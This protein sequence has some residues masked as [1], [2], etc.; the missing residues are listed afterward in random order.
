VEGKR[1]SGGG[2]GEGGGIRGKGEGEG[3]EEVRGWG[4]KIRVGV[5]ERGREGGRPTETE[6]GGTDHSEGRGWKRKSGLLPTR[7][8]QNI[9]RREELAFQS[10]SLNTTRKKTGNPKNQTPIGKKRFKVS[11]L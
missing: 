2:G 4:N 1:E 9:R 8:S 10:L 7:R 3:A 6:K 5:G 11:R